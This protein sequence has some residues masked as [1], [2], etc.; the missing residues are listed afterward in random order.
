MD[1]LLEI[2]ER[3]ER[4]SGPVALATLLDGRPGARRILEPGAGLDEP[5]REVL[6]G[7]PSRVLGA[8]LDG[9][10]DGDL[11]LEHLVPGKLP[12]WLH[13]CAQVLRRGGSCVLVTVGAVAGPVPYAPGDRFVFD[14]RNH[15]LLP[16]DGRFSL[17]L[18]RACIRARAA[19]VPVR[20]RFQLAGGSLGILLEPLPST[21]AIPAVILAAGASRRLGRPKQLVELEGESLL[22]RTVRAALAGCA[23]VLVV[24]GARGEDMAAHLEGLPVTLVRNEAWEEGM[25]SSLRAGIRALPAGAEAVLFLVCD[26]PAVDGAL[27]RR[28]L[29]VRREHPE[30]VVACGYAGARGTPS[31]FPAHCFAQLLELRGDRGARGLLAGAG[32]EVVPFP[33]GDADVDYPEDL[34]P[35]NSPGPG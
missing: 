15:G 16:M 12:P 24:V 1:D 25:A 2:I 10:P 18:Q 28:L 14:E 20:E 26:Q 7:G 9:W 19:G 29:Q 35:G 6:A 33:E 3:L 17:E 23:P 8:H 5:V 34:P 30:A 22:R 11:L 4:R 13:V 31:I 32:V 21:P 27:V